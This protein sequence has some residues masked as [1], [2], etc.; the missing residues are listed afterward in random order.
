[1]FEAGRSLTLERGGLKVRTVL[2]GWKESQ[3]L[4]VDIPGGLWTTPSKEPILCKLFSAGAARGFKTQFL[5][6][7][8]E[9]QLLILK[10]PSNIVDK[11]NRSSSRFNTTLP[12][13]VLGGPDGEQERGKG[14][15]TNISKGGCQIV[16]PTHSGRLDIG[17]KLYLRASLAAGSTI[18]KAPCQLRRTTRSNG[19]IIYNV[20]FNI[21]VREN[22]TAVHEFLSNLDLF[23]LKEKEI[24]TPPGPVDFIPTGEFCQV[25][26]EDFKF[27]S[28]FRGHFSPN[29]FLMDIPSLKGSVKYIPHD[30]LITVRFIHKGMAYG[31]E[32]TLI[33]MYTK[34]STIC[35]LEYPQQIN[36]IYLRKSLRLNI[37]LLSK[38]QAQQRAIDG[39]I[40]D[41]S[42]GGCL[43]STQQSGIKVG[44][45]C[46]LES[47]LPTGAKIDRLLCQTRSLRKRGDKMMMGLDFGKRESNLSFHQEK[48]DSYALLKSYYDECMIGSAFAQTPRVV[49]DD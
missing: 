19:Q 9:L 14:V 36:N 3:Y 28:V 41:L 16:C 43:L 48:K 27:N 11:T 37:F 26:V 47:H 39:A 15:I 18:E 20:K 33:R 35:I 7:L 25:Q 24:L 4:L 40:I 45:N 38:L 10:Y 31:F 49:E 44:E 30:C 46:F 23:D 32:T 34:P 22:L 8:R 21:G 1:M 5:G 42:K 17:D 6:V 13:S 2:R 12:V 29:Y